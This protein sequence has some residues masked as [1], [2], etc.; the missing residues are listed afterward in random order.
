M[1][2]CFYCPSSVQNSAVLHQ[3]Y[4]YLELVDNIWYIDAT[5]NNQ[6]W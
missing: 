2:E 1:D 5:I 4:T 3:E 6:C